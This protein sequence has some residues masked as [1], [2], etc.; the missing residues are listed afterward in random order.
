MALVTRWLLLGLMGTFLLSG[1]SFSSFSVEPPT[2]E[3]IQQ[4]IQKNLPKDA[5]LIHAKD[6]FHREEIITVD[7]NQDKRMEGIAFYQEDGKKDQVHVLIVEKISDD[8]WKKVILTEQGSELQ[9]VDLVDLTGDGRP[10][11]TFI[12]IDN[13]K[14]QTVEPEGVQIP[15]QKVVVYD[16]AGEKP[17]KRL[18]KWVSEGAAAFDFDGD[19]KGE[20]ILFDRKYTEEEMRLELYQFKENKIQLVDQRSDIMARTA[21]TYF[22]AGKLNNKLNGVVVNVYHYSGAGFK[23]YTVKKG[24]LKEVP[25]NGKVP[26]YSMFSGKSEDINRDGILEIPVISEGTGLAEWYQLKENNQFQK[27]YETYEN[28]VHGFRIHLPKKWQGQVKWYAGDFGNSLPGQE[29]DMVSITYKTEEF[30]ALIEVYMND[31]ILEQTS[32]LLE[33][34]DKHIP[35]TFIE[36]PSK[37]AKILLGI[38]RPAGFTIEQVKKWVEWVE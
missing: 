14:T 34:R 21:T 31:K 23:I 12:M 6:G 10:E 35:Y 37:K 27:V 16:L 32:I 18:E 11:I 8:E 25:V 20:L 19:K 22:N 17:N 24:K 1:C 13:T 15:Y 28:F 30:P 38:P 2:K 7:L 5:I 3:E 26:E 29:Q 4:A 9:R 36:S 33:Y